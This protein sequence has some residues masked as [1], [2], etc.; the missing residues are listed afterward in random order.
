M[1]INTANPP[2]RFVPGI[3]FAKLIHWSFRRGF[4]DI[5]QQNAEFIS[6]SGGH[7]HKQ[8]VVLEHLY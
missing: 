3:S 1:M 8:A 2:A 4:E 7:L 6:G 5:V